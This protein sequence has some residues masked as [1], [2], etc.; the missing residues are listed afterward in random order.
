MSIPCGYGLGGGIT[1]VAGFP[2]S[3]EFLDRFYEH[4]YGKCARDINFHG[5]EHDFGALHIT[6]FAITGSKRDPCGER[7]HACR[8]SL[9]D[10]HYW[11]L[12]RKRKPLDSTCLLDQITDVIGQ[13]LAIPCFSLTL[14]SVSLRKNQNIRLTFA[15]L[16]ANQ[17]TIGQILQIPAQAKIKQKT[18]PSPLNLHCTIGRTR[19]LFA[20]FDPQRDRIEQNLLAAVDAMKPL[21]INVNSLKLVH[22]RRASLSGINGYILLPLRDHPQNSTVAAHLQKR[23]VLEYALGLNEYN[24]RPI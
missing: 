1:L 5:R 3:D 11:T 2:L 9:T 21:T 7:A 15:A 10:S 23:G 24:K 17:K 4:I 8:I 22:Y 16:D 20:G 19:T 6:L 14:N 13:V 12:E 18:K